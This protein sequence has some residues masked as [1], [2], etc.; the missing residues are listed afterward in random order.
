M[1]VSSLENAVV[2]NN[3]NKIEVALGY[4]TLYG[5]AIGAL[6][7][8]GDL[9]KM[10]VG[11][12]AQSLNEI[13]QAEIVPQNLIP[14]DEAT[15]VSWEFAPSAELKDDQFDPM[16]WGYHDAL[17][18]FLQKDS[19]EDLLASYLDGTI[20]HTKLGSYLKAYQLDKPEAFIEDLKWV[21]RTMNVAV[22]KR[23]QM[24]PI[25]SVSNYAYGM[26]YRESQLPQTYTQKQRALI[27]SILK[28]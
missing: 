26:T 6:A 15:H 12:V 21:I 27:E 22:Y 17:I 23:I 16:K 7:I 9:T 11:K 10:E 3:G 28:M 13:A 5:D 4:A 2:S 8:L 25:V 14:L 18:E 1:S 19:L 20:Y 24:P